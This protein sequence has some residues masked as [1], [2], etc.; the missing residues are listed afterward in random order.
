MCL[1]VP[2][3]LLRSGWI[4]CHKI[5]WKDVVLESFYT[6]Q[7]SPFSVESKE[8]SQYMRGCEIYLSLKMAVWSIRWKGSNRPFPNWFRLW[9]WVEQKAVRAPNL[10]PLHLYEMKATQCI[11]P[12]IRNLLRNSPRPPS[13]TTKFDVSICD[14]IGHHSG[15]FEINPTIAQGKSCLNNFNWS[16]HYLMCQKRKWYQKIS[17]M[18]GFFSKCN[19]RFVP[20]S[21]V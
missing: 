18:L 4:Y 1:S 15:K 10:G 3:D 6:K 8:G 12:Y 9:Y 21:L 13:R 14:K 2:L 17:R 19:L 16:V 5:W 20:I 7:V 11:S